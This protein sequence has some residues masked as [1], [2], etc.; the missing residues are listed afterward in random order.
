LCRLEHID[1]MTSSPTLAQRVRDS[2]VESRRVHTF[3]LGVDA[4]SQPDGDGARELLR[5]HG[6]TGEFLLTV[7]TVE[8]RKNLSRLNAAVHNA[9]SL[10][11][12]VVVGAAGWGEVQTDA[13]RLVGP[14]SEGI[15]QALRHM[16]RAHVFVPVAEGWGLPA[17]E[18]LAAG[19]PLLVSATVP[20][21]VGRADALVVDPCDVDALTDGLLRVLDAEQSEE[22]ASR[23][24]ASVASLTWA[25]CAR[26]HVAVWR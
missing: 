20:S 17:V 7:G 11:P 1:I 22:A 15:V 10:P 26:D 24:Q 5:R 21:A 8:P 13:L 18:A 6:I 16:A 9:A 19:R 23:R 14:Q 2:G 4:S 25:S 3:T 12:V